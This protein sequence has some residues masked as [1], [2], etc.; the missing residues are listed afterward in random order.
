MLQVA[1]PYEGNGLAK[2]VG[3]SE[4]EQERMALALDYWIEKIGAKYPDQQAQWS[5]GAVA[6]GTPAVALA[7]QNKHLQQAMRLVYDAAQ[8]EVQLLK[9]GDGVDSPL[10][11]RLFEVGMDG[12]ND[13]GTITRLLQELWQKKMVA[14]G[15]SREIIEVQARAMDMESLLLSLQDLSE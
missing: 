14:Q 3:D 7:P 2:V 5:A 6:A 13:E 1:T 8:Q 9:G 10:L 11:E 15:M 12:W 4:D